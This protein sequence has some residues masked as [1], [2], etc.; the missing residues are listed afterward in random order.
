MVVRIGVGG[1]WKLLDDGRL[2]IRWV[3]RDAV[4]GLKG[5]DD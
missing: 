3:H 4:I 1:V 2:V 5:G